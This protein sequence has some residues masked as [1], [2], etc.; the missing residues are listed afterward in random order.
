MAILRQIS[1]LGHPVLRQEAALVAAADDPGVQGLLEDMLLTV[2]EAD[3]LGLAAPQV[4]ESLSLF[5]MACCPNARYPEAPD[6]PPI[7][8]INPEILWASDRIDSG[9][10]G[11]LSIPSLRGLVPRH[12]RIGV[13]Y[14]DSRGIQREEEYSDLPARIF[15]HE[16]DHVRGMMFIDRIVSSRDLISEKEYFRMMQQRD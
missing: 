5:I 13:R 7:A 11:C 14:L 6:L 4:Y 2:A 8:V 3:G 12:Q 10:E 9:W 15:Q 1:Q 16:Y